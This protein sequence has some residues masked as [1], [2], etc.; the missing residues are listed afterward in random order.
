MIAIPINT[1]EAAILKLRPQIDSAIAKRKAL[2]KSFKNDKRKK[3]TLFEQKYLKDLYDDFEQIV[4]AQP[5]QLETFKKQFGELPQESRTKIKGSPSFKDKL[6]DVLDYAS[7]RGILYPQFFS[8]IGIKSCVY[9]NSQLAVVVE[10]IE[11][12]KTKTNVSLSAKFDVDHNIGKAKYPCFSISFYNLYPVCTSCNRNK[13]EKEVGFQ[14]YSNSKRLI[15]RSQF[16]FSLTPGSAAKY[17]LSKDIKDIEIIFNEPGTGSPLDRPF[18]STFDITSIYNTQK[19]VVEE[20]ILKSQIYTDSYKE[21]LRV[22]FPT[23]FNDVNLSNRMIIGNYG[24]ENEIHKRPL[25]KFTLDIAQD[26]GLIKKN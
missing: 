19:D 12:L 1:V 11:E 23:I 18:Q 4:L 26:L 13:K 17:C 24:N 7:L 20:L 10:V 22:E 14:L 5:A 16:A 8:H 21:K 3:F 25:A 15:S 2:L 9:C 6:L